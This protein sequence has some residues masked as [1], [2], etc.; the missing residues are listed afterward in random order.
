[1]IRILNETNN[2][3]LILGI[4]S[5]FYKKYHQ[6]LDEEVDKRNMSLVHYELNLDRVADIGKNPEF[7]RYFNDRIKSHVKKATVRAKI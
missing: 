1:M 7:L 4:R 6:D 5:D 2:V 3:K